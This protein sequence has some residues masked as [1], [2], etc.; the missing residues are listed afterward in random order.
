MGCYIVGAEGF[1]GPHR[2]S[3]ESLTGFAGF[4]IY[5]VQTVTDRLCLW[6]FLEAV[7][8]PDI[9]LKLKL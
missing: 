5:F 8:L 6:W 9:S 3:C 2:F 1:K 4:P 7:T